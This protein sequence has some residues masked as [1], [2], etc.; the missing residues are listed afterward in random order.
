MVRL[1]DVP[2]R[3]L[4]AVRSGHTGRGLAQ[5]LDHELAMRDP[6][7]P[8]RAGRRGPVG[9]GH[10]PV[11]GTLVTGVL[12]RLVA[13]AA[14]S[15][16]TGLE[17]ARETA[18]SGGREGTAVHLPATLADSL[19]SRLELGLNAGGGADGGGDRGADPGAVARGRRAGR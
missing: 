17:L 10:G 7:G 1:K 4:V 11:P 6:G 8:G 14:G 19:R 5:L 3:W 9:A 16:Y 15:P 2:V 13:L 18:A 12:H